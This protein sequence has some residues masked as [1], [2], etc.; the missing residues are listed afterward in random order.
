MVASPDLPLNSLPAQSV[1][2]AESASSDVKPKQL[3]DLITDDDTVKALTV[4]R[5]VRDDSD[6]PR[7]LRLQAADSLLDRKHGKARQVIDQEIKMVTFLDV[8]HSGIIKE[9][10]YQ[11]ILNGQV[12]AIEEAEVI[13]EISWDDLI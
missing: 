12:A 13:P 3:K 5:E 6:A 4:L 10:K 2:P 7:N 9:A 11:A 1:P 8:A